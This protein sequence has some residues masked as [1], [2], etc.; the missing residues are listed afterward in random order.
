M[1]EIDINHHLYMIGCFLYFTCSNIKTGKTLSLYWVCMHIQG[2]RLAVTQTYVDTLSFIFLL[3]L[4]VLSAKWSSS[5]AKHIKSPCWTAKD[6]TSVCKN[7]QT[8][9]QTH[10]P[11]TLTI[12]FTKI[13]TTPYITSAH[14]SDLRH[15]NLN[16]LI[17]LH[18]T[19][20]KT[21]P[22]LN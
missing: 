13:C 9:S 15:I 10:T 8:G 14:T 1:P 16:N 11:S 21:T 5:G 2:L 20:Q 6:Y 12:I 7:I 3:T 19:S 4:H 18:T 22:I 17:W